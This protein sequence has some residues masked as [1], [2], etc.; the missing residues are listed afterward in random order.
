MQRL[1]RNRRQARFQ[2][3]QIDPAGDLTDLRS[4]DCDSLLRQKVGVDLAVDELE[5]IQ[6]FDTLVTVEHFATALLDESLGKKGIA[7]SRSR[8][9]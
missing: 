6:I 1:C 9:P 7:V 2:F 4:N 5:F 3:R 8:C